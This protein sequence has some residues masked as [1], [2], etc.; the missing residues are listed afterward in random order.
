MEKGE[1]KQEEEEEELRNRRKTKDKL[2]Q[3]WIQLHPLLLSS[4]LPLLLVT[5]TAVTEQISSPG[6]IIRSG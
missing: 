5:V 1:E 3:T 2:L 6:H 4:H